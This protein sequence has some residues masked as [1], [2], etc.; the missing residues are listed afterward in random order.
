MVL[1]PG[2]RFSMFSGT[3]DE[4]DLFMVTGVT[5]DTVDLV[6]ERFKIVPVVAKNK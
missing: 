2:V 4:Y 1:S 3:P 6:G 5:Q